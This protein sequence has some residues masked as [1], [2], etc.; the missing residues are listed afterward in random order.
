MLNRLMFIQTLRNRLIV[1]GLLVAAS[2]FSLFPRSQTI[3]ER[4]PDGADAGHGR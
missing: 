3:R 4:G 1:I 2:V